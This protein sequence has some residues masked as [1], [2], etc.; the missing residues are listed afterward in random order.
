[1]AEGSKRPK[2]PSAMES[3]LVVAS[4]RGPIAFEQDARGEVKPRKGSGGL[5]TALA[6]VFFH[7]DATWVAAAMTDPDVSIARRGRPASSTG[8]QR[9][10]FVEIPADR[11]ELAYNGFSNRVLWFTQHYL[12]DLARQP[13]FGDDTRRAWE[14]YVETNQDFAKELA[15]E[16]GR[17]PVF[18]VQDYHL[19]LVPAM[20]REIVPDSRIV[21][22][23][24]TPF[25]GPQYLRILPN[26]IREDILRG[27]A[28]ADVIGFQSRAWAENFLL[29]ARHV[30][31]LKVDLR[32]GRVVTVA[33]GH[34]AR[35]RVYP[36]AVN[37]H[38]LRELEG[39]R[40]VDA[41]RREVDELRGDRRLLLRVDR[42][43]PSKNVLRGFLAFELFLQRHPEWRERVVFLS[44]LSPSRDKMPEY[45][46]Y[47]DECMNEAARI[48][49]EY[50]SPSW[51]PVVTRVQEDFPYAVAAYGSY[52]ALLVNP[53]FDGMNLVSME[54]PVVNPRNG[55]LVLSRNAGAF[56]R[57]GR[58]ALAVNPFDVDQTADAMA[59]AFSMPLEERRRRARGLVRAVTAHTPESWLAAQLQ[60]LDEIRRPRRRS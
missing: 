32:A 17:Q 41:A 36:V 12:W 6:G 18:L 42:M 57:I 51:S 52:D 13:V 15:K 46:A 10:R 50:G 47:A 58:H 8:R 39:D 30:P 14:A 27:M 1:M 11:F 16:A 20:L 53:V 54:G 22:F 40:Y 49:D 48:D 21:H 3:P 19:F 44:L 35:V 60:D 31:G 7:D 59:E 45:Q 2:V 23:S 55:V 28:G 26:R 29:S 5:V 37:P 9:L 25:A 43:E 33:D 56:E 38:A 24:H 34:E 4:N